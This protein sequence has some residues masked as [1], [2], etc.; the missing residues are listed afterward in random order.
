MVWQRAYSNLASIL[1]GVLLCPTPVFLG[2]SQQ[3]LGNPMLLLA[4]KLALLFASLVEKKAEK[5]SNY[6]GLGLS[7]AIGIASHL[8]AI[9]SFVSAQYDTPDI[10][11]TLS[12]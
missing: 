12:Q 1:M 3:I 9:G 7:L 11:P 4:T 10:L 6:V 5:L 8:Q 2:Y